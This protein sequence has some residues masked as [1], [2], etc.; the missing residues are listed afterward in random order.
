MLFTI[1]AIASAA[2]VKIIVFFNWCKLERQMK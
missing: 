2:N 1:C